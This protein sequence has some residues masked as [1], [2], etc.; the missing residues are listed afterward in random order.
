MN[1]F[2]E[3]IQSALEEFSRHE[4]LKIL[5]VDE[6]ESKNFNKFTDVW[7]VISEV[8]TQ[9]LGLKDFKFYVCFNIEFPL[10]LP[11]IYLSKEDFDD[12]KWIPH[13]NEDGFICTYDPETIKINFTS[14]NF[15]YWVVYNCFKRAKRILKDGIE[16][17]NFKD[18]EDEFIN[19]WGIKYSNNNCIDIGWLSIITSSDIGELDLKVDYLPSKNKKRHNFIVHDNNL[20]YDQVKNYLI[21]NG[22]E[23]KEYQAFYLGEIGIRNPPF[24][25]KNRNV[26]EIIKNIGD[27]KKEIFENYINT[28]KEL[29]TVIFKKRI[30]DEDYFLGWYFKRIKQKLKGFRSLKFNNYLAISWLQKEDYVIRIKPDVYNLGKFKVRTSGKLAKDLKKLIFLVAGLGSIGSN[31]IYFLNSIGSPSFRL[32]D[33]DKL[34][35]DNIGRHLLGYSHIDEDKT[36]AIRNFIKE[37]MPHQQVIIKNESILSVIQKD[38]GFINDSDFIFI[39]I[40]SNTIEDWLGKIIGNG[41]IKKP[42]FFI[43]VEPYLVGGHCLYINSESG[44]NYKDYFDING[45]FKFSIIESGEYSKKKEKLISR[46]AGCNTTY[47]PYSYSNVILFLSSLFPKIH[48]VISENTRES[49][50][51]SWAGDMTILKELDIK[52]SEY[53]KKIKSGVLNENTIE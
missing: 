23:I 24:E 1:F 53:G 14:P 18:F 46:V 6:I 28:N 42:T 51:L 10:S 38:P 19:Y 22:I 13:V 35:I 4:K 9:K 52:I 30:E 27:K 3:E 11:K 37:K 48:K 20:I 5:S 45:F 7:E 47:T 8:E 31:L 26:L 29:F 36:L 21:E 34:R 49:L 39:A 33:F 44:L 16:K 12:V 40:G 41:I 50:C 2:K 32:I 17:N 25:L 43:W 15:V